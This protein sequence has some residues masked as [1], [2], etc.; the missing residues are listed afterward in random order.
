MRLAAAAPEDPSLAVAT[1]AA[2]AA[3]KRNGGGVQTAEVSEERRASAEARD[4]LLPVATHGLGLLQTLLDLEQEE[5]TPFSFLDA[6]AEDDREDG[7]EPLLA[8]AVGAVL[9]ACAES[10]D[11]QTEAASAGW[12]GEEGKGWVLVAREADGGGE[13]DAEKAEEEE[14]AAAPAAAPGEFTGLMEDDGATEP[15]AK[16]AE[17]AKGAGPDAGPDAGPEAAN[18]D[19]AK[20][21]AEAAAAETPETPPPLPPPVGRGSGALVLAAMRSAEA[22]SVDSSTQTATMDALAAPLARVLALPEKAFAQWWCGGA[23]SRY[24]HQ[25]DYA[26]QTAAA[27]AAAETAT[28][29][30]DGAPGGAE[31]MVVAG[32]TYRA[33]LGCRVPLDLRPELAKAGT[34]RVAERALLLHHLL[35][36]LHIHD[37]RAEEGAPR[38]KFLGLLLDALAGDHLR[39]RAAKNLAALHEHV[40]G[41]LPEGTVAGHDVVIVQTL[42][43]EWAARLPG[44]GGEEAA[45][46]A[47]A[48]S[49]AA[50]AAAAPKAK[51]PDADDVPL[52]QMVE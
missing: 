29:T 34:L 4:A 39:R 6:A 44:G 27:A 40:K 32:V 17:A 36:N 21:A 19:S 25:D 38:G 50:A 11:A 46:A 12:M 16:E 13:R 1:E 42:L 35:G 45:E 37:A 41:D 14:P 5:P 9:R 10:L 30:R 24:A 20:E 47:A 3:A 33:D 31:K 7:C 48:A 49:A 15:E 22:L 51:T 23:A 26:A 43:D 52:A 28:Q 8:A 2:E 18:G